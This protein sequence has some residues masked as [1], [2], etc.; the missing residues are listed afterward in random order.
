MRAAEIADPF[1]RPR[2][3]HAACLA[4]AVAEAER[5]CAARGARLTAIRR[6]VLEIV[7]EG[8]GP[9]G[10]YDILERLSAERRRI[11][12][13]TV[14]RALDFLTDQGLVHRIE[15]SNAFVGCAQPGAPHRAHFLICGRCGDAAELDD[16][17]LRG[18]LARV[19]ERAGFAVERETVELKGLCPKCRA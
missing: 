1:A 10:A 12:P 17:Q 4:H 2:H 18:A 11:A 5:V 3:D 7:W 6:R 8:H 16:A 19:A 13:P 14:Y 15:S 9:L